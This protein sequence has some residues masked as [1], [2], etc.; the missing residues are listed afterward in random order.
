MLCR[1]VVVLGLLVFRDGCYFLLRKRSRNDLILVV[2]WRDVIPC[3][4]APDILILCQKTNT[5][6]E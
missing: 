4:L 2:W 3:I 6:E 5:R 1:L